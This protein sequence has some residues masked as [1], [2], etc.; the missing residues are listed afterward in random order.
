MVFRL[1]S[2]RV[3]RSC[4]L[5]VPS[6]VLARVAGRRRR[7]ADRRADAE[8]AGATTYLHQIDFAGRL[9]P[10]GRRTR[11]SGSVRGSTFVATTRDPAAT[12]ASASRS[13]LASPGPFHVA[14]AACRAR[15]PV[16]VRIRPRARTLARRRARRGRPL[17][18]SARSR[19]SYAGRVR[20]RVIRRAAA[21]TAARR[22]RADVTLGTNAIESVRV[23]S[24]TLPQPGFDAAH[25]RA[26]ALR[27]G[28]RASRSAHDEPG[29]RGDRSPARARST[30]WCRALARRSATTCS[31]A[32]T[33]S[34]RWRASTGPASVDAAFWTQPRRAAHPAAPL[35]PPGGPHRGRQDPP[36][37]LRRP[38]RAR[39]P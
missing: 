33:P 15:T 1:C 13:R 21:S 14:L 23:A 10:G 30:T 31:R 5:R 8:G 11:A 25:P 24:T 16:T 38:R 17:P 29:R 26:A 20:V 36:G 3:R 35:P 2:R 6:L 37:A 34:R 39:S 4:S 28:R 22:R 18:R 32:S 9:S 27:C 7:A 12:A 19:P